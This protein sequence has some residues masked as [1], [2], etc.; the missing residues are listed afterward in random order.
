M[1]RTEGTA[2]TSTLEIVEL[3]KFEQ[4]FFSYA[5]FPHHFS[6]DHCQRMK[7]LTEPFQRECNIILKK[8]SHYCDHFKVALISALILFIAHYH[9]GSF[10]DVCV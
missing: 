2:L 6:S 4:Y 1:W 7:T 9:V 10:S 5:L 3:I 8:K